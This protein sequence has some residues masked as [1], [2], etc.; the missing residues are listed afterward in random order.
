[1]QK[2]Q[3]S[4]YDQTTKTNIQNE[5]RSYVEDQLMPKVHSTQRS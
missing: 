5:T 2:R 3:R 1:M 4:Q